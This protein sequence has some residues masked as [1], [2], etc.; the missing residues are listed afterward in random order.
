MD[1]K[2]DWG[3]DGAAPFC[4]ERCPSFDGK[5]CEVLG[6]RPGSLCEPA[7]R[8]AIAMAIRLISN[9]PQRAPE[10]FHGHPALE[11][12]VSIKVDMRSRLDVVEPAPRCTGC[13]SDRTEYK[14][15]DPTKDWRCLDCKI[16]YSPARSLPTVDAPSPLRSFATAGEPEGCRHCGEKWCTFTEPRCAEAQ[17]EYQRAIAKGMPPSGRHG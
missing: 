1:V 3:S 9:A 6:H 8:D 10:S 7:V 2:P 5:R 15:G 17:K 16:V 14:D 12:Q 4:S 11:V 13:R